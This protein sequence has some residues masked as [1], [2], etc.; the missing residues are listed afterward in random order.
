[1][2]I[3]ASLKD[4][5]CTGVIRCLNKIYAKE[6]VGKLTGNADTATAL[7]TSEGSATQPVYF[8]GGKPVACNGMMTKNKKFYMFDSSNNS[9]AL[10]VTTILSGIGSGILFSYD[11]IILTLISSGYG[12]AVYTL[13]YGGSTSSTKCSL[14]YIYGNIDLID[15]GYVSVT[16]N[17]SCDGATSGSNIMTQF[18]FTLATCVY[19]EYIPKFTR[20]ALGGNGSEITSF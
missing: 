18:T 19:I 2:I 9:I 12:R 20:V 5:I 3:I 6:F 7:T 15:S 8:N 11:D 13:S 17:S 4:I 1:M 14:K 16:N 10:T